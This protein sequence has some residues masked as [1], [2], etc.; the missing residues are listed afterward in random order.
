MR[1]LFRP[2]FILLVFLVL[3]SAGCLQPKIQ[4]PT[5]SVSNVSLSDVSL[6]TMTVNTTIVIFNPNPVGAKLNRL[7]F[8][9]NYLDDTPH[10]LGHGEKS[11]IEVKSNDNTT[12]IVPV[13]ISNVQAIS[14][15]G[16]L[17]RKGS[18]NV[19]VNG[20]AFIDLKVIS[21]EKRFLHTKEFPLSDFESLL[22]TAIPGISG[23]VTDKLRTLGQLLNS[24]S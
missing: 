19:T 6:Q 13:T 15:V 22:P 8:D 3:L 23:N 5:V 7:V 11:D 20:S 2:V 9:I 21:Y 18:L 17:I 24:V 16:T 12:V 10:Y 4:E 14:A 1:P